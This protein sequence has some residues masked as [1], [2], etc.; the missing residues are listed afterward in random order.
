MRS[1]GA[2]SL[3]RP[4]PIETSLGWVSGGLGVGWVRGGGWGG[5]GGGMGR[6]ECVRD[7]KVRSVFCFQ[8]MFPLVLIWKINNKYNFIKQNN[9]LGI[10]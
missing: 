10:N 3:Y 5:G 9:C 8:K 4:V 2:K 6:G 7:N 1:Q